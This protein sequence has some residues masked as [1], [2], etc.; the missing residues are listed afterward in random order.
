M[1]K[2]Y[3]EIKYKYLVW[4]IKRALAKDIKKPR[5]YTY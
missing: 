1:L 3:K 5:R 2:I 4:K